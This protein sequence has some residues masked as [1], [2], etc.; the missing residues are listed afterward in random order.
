MSIRQNDP[1][2]RSRLAALLV[3]VLV[4]FF[5]VS[6]YFWGRNFTARDIALRE[7]PIQQLQ[8]ESQTLEAYSR[9]NRESHLAAGRSYECSGH[10]G[11][12]MPAQE[13]L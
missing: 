10:V 11:A 3:I 6:G 9:S 8:T 4:L 1:A 13:H 5:M 2:P 12:I 7:Q